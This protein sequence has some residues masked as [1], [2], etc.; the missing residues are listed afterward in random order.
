ME[1]EVEK[2]VEVSQVEAVESAPLEVKKSSKS[3][4]IVTP[5][6][7]ERKTSEDFPS[8]L[9]S[10]PPPTPID[11]SPLQQ[12]QQAAANASALAEALKLPAETITQCRKTAYVTDDQKSQLKNNNDNACLPTEIIDV[13]SIE[14]SDLDNKLTESKI[15]NVDELIIHTEEGPIPVSSD[16]EEIIHPIIQLTKEE[17]I[18]KKDDDEECETET[19]VTSE[20]SLPGTGND[21]DN[22]AETEVAITEIPEDESLSIDIKDENKIDNNEDE[23]PPPLPE[24]PIPMPKASADLLNFMSTQI[25]EIPVLTTDVIK[26]VTN[27]IVEDILA[28][29]EV[30]SITNNIP[31]PPAPVTAVEEVVVL[32]NVPE[33]EI[34]AVVESYDVDELPLPPPEP[35]AYE[36]VPESVSPSPKSPIDDLLTPPRSPSPNN[37]S[38]Q[39]EINGHGN[40]KEEEEKKEK[41]KSHSKVESLEQSLNYDFQL[42]DRLAETLDEEITSI[43]RSIKHNNVQ[44]I[45]QVI[46]NQPPTGMNRT[47]K[48][49]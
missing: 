42:K 24:S 12:A 32:T 38:S 45:E 11:P 47:V 44:I 37:E 16:I 46:N 9:P 14:L 40:N 39:L 17:I 27:P 19:I 29:N 49:C 4:P 36:Q 26:T 48:H 20:E 33:V 23:I 25:E 35:A 15:I 41:E 10:S 28:F 22:D 21:Q 7:I 30:D 5:S 18:L 34:Q 31:L 43:D 8:L 2:Q 1:K 13:K 3:Q 6:I